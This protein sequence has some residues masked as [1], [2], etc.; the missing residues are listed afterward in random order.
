MSYVCVCVSVFKSSFYNERLIITNLK[1][2]LEWLN[3]WVYWDKSNII[4]LRLVNKLKIVG[5]C[6]IQPDW[7]LNFKTDG[8]RR[9]KTNK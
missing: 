7:T 1:G 2:Q 6:N 8:S 4:L 3:E 9:D 5:L